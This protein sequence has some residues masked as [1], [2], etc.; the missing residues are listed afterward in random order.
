MSVL[1][2]QSNFLDLF[3]GEM[4]AKIYSVNLKY[5]SISLSQSEIPVQYMQK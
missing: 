1:K 4:F 2:G 3:L 5:F